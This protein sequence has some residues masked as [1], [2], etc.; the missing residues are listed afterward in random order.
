MSSK[1]TDLIKLDHEKLTAI[2]NS[3][4][5]PGVPGGAVK[6]FGQRIFLVEAIVAGTTHLNDDPAELYDRLQVGDRL[7]FFRETDNPHD[8]LAIVVKNPQ[9]GK[10]GYE[11]RQKNEILARLMD[12]GKLV[13]GILTEKELVRKWLKLTMEVHLDD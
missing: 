1:S 8:E 13:F 4:T 6:P 5:P 9:C 7:D 10:M 12:A 2:L 3:Q 11:S